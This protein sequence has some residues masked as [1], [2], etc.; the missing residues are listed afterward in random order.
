M[1][2]VKLGLAD[3][4]VLE[5]VQLGETVHTSLTGNPDFTPDPPLTDLATATNELRYANEAVRITKL[6]WMA[7]VDVQEQ[8][9]TAFDGVMTKESNTVENQSNGDPVKIGSAGMQV[10]GTATPPAAMPKVEDAS[11]T[12]GD[13]DSE[14]DINWKPVK[15]KKT[16]IVE[17]SAD[18]ISPTSWQQAGLT[19]KSKFTVTGLTSGAKYWFRIAASGSAGSGPW[20][21]PCTARA[22]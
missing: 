4:T 18:P 19:T 20:S 14:A 2:K 5:K 6:A 15:K 8:K 7:A 10:Q 9:E 22:T 11:A 1:A 3:I 12:G 21:D 16:Y 13:L 17:F